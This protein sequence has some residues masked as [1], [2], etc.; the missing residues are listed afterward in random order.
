RL[1]ERPAGDDRGD[2]ERRGVAG[3]LVPLPPE[4][5]ERRAAGDDRGD[6]ADQPSAVDQAVV[7][8]LGVVAQHGE[9][10]ERDRA[11]DETGRERAGAELLLEPGLALPGGVGAEEDGGQ[12]RGGHDGE[13]ADQ[14]RRR[15]EP[16]RPWVAGGIPD[17]DAPPG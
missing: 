6:Q 2:G 5:P 12:V 3:G 16:A 9:A 15:V 14:Q 10:R 1:R 8:R 4:E 17:R 11:T 13:D 7:E